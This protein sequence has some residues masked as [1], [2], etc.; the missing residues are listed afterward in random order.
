MEC[1]WNEDPAQV[2]HQI[3]A[4]D[5][6]ITWYE[7]H[8]P[9]PGDEGVTNVQPQA[10]SCDPTDFARSQTDYISQPTSGAAALSVLRTNDGQLLP[11][12]DYP[13][14]KALT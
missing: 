5:R 10:E 7:K 9:K 11:N 2:T 3:N 1:V 13:E 6:S 14:L 4:T 8:L 12:P